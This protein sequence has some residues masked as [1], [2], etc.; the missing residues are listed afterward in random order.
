ME[1]LEGE[2]VTVRVWGKFLQKLWPILIFLLLMV[3][4][5]RPPE[6]PPVVPAPVIESRNC[7]GTGR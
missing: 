3:S 4:C 2:S 7:K 5:A 6:P 1:R